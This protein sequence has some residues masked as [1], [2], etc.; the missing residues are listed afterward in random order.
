M[1]SI[2]P[3]SGVPS[4]TNKGVRR[5]Q[6]SRRKKNGKEGRKNLTK[7]SEGVGPSQQ[8][9]KDRGG[10]ELAFEERRPALTRAKGAP[11]ALRKNDF[12]PWVKRGALNSP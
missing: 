6:R 3:S 4:A 5:T 9:K 8:Q 12:K 1:E 10:K 2:D 7:K 11:R